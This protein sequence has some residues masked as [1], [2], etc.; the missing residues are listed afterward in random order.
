MKTKLTLYAFLIAVIVSSAFSQT[1]PVPEIIYYKFNA[2]TT[3]TPNY[4]IPG[5]GTNPAPVGVHTLGG[6]GQFDSA[7]VGGGGNGASAYVNSGWNMD[8]GTSSWTISMWFS[9][10]TASGTYYMFGNNTASTS[11]RC[12]T[13]GAAGVGNI[14]LRATGFTN[15]N[16]TGVL[17]G[18][19][20]VHFVYDSA[21]TTVKTYVNGVFQSS[22][23]QSP[24]NIVSTVAFLVGGYG[25]SSSFG[26][27]PVG[28][29]MDEFRVYRRALDATEVAATW[30]HLLPYTVTGVVNTGNSNPNEYALGQNYPNPFNPVTNIKYSIPVA[31]FTELKVYDMLGR[32]VE[33]IV[34]SFQQAGSYQAT[35]TGSGLASGVYTYRISSGSFTETLK[36]IL[37][38]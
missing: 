35:F 10:L 21:S 31:G 38:K 7:L 27:I 29:L 34:S 33:T 23:G 5:F 32:E 13:N 8:F 15:V 16:V 1:Y 12:F 25:H 36:M 37:V 30:N 2:G 20:V 14:T 24:L 3:A 11:F 6:V 19:N 22:V 28:A 26:S 18:T 9:G 4:A 17:P